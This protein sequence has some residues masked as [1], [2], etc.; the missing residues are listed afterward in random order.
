MHTTRRR[1]TSTTSRRA[2]PGRSVL[3]GLAVLALPAALSLALAACTPDPAPAPSAT[4]TASPTAT[5]TETPTPTAVAGAL[6]PEGT[7]ADNKAF[8]DSTNQALI[9]ANPAAGGVDFTSN[10]RT[11]GFDITA[12]QVTPDITTVGVA[13]DSIQFSVRWGADCLIGQYGQ[14]V[15]TSSVMPALGTGSCLVGQTRAIDW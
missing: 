8:F 5:P 15:Y 3:R 2:L 7:A 11:N 12:M 13:A 10:L 4:T 9:A 1:S 14:G 6:N